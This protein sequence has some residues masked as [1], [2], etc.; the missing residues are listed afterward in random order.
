MR[1]LG[2]FLALGLALI[3]ALV[4]LSLLGLGCGENKDPC[5]GTSDPVVAAI[6]SWA[7]FVGVLASVLLARLGFTRPAAIV[8]TTTA[9]TYGAWLFLLLR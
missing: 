2:S 3:A 4:T 6:L 9:L 7:G 8:V 1:G 5:T